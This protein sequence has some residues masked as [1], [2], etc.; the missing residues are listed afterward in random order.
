LPAKAIFAKIHATRH[1]DSWSQSFI[2]IYFSTA[3]QLFLAVYQ[4][5]TNKE[6]FKKSLFFEKIARW[7]V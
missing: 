1:D 2:R 4:F 7:F 3:L 5:E 6:E